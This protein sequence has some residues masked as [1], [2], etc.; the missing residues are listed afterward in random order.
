MTLTWN[1]EVRSPLLFLSP[2]LACD[3]D[4]LGASCCK[5]N[6]QQI[7]RSS[8]FLFVRCVGKMVPFAGWAMPVQYKDSLMESARHCRDSASIFD[9]S[10]M[11]GI[12]FKVH[13]LSFTVCQESG[14]TCSLCQSD[15]MHVELAGQRGGAFPRKA[16]GRRRCRN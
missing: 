7:L 2:K 16:G 13:W 11:C 14:P 12:T 9:V 10:H 1:R 8:N 3:P 5:H 6:S 15:F 4:D